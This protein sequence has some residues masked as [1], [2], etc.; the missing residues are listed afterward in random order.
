MEKFN[1]KSFSLV[2]AKGKNMSHGLMVIK[3]YNSDIGITWKLL[4]VIDGS[5]PQRF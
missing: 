5:Q 4:E 3:H 2:I 1:I